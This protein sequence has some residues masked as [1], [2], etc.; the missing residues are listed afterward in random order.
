ML[1]ILKNIMEVYQPQPARKGRRSAVLIPLIK[2]DGEWHVIYEERSK[3]VP[4]SGDASFPGGGIK[5]N[6]SP[7][8]AAVRE[9]M[10]ELNLKEEQIDVYGEMDYLANEGD[11]I[12]SFVGEIKG[13][14]FEEIVANEE[15]ESLFTIPLQHLIEKDPIFFNIDAKLEFPDNFPFGRISYA[16]EFQSRAKSQTIPYYPISDY[17]LWGFTAELTYRFS[18]LLRTFGYSI[19]GGEESIGKRPQ[20]DNDIGTSLQ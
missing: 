7:E 13:L 9:T 20:K 12:Y 4:Q 17:L 8:Q 19:E 11:I 14:S 16:K 18:E 3:L 1:T 5:L 2:R 15:I 10:E 6:E